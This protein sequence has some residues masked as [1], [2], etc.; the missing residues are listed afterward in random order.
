M[1]I[2][3]LTMANLS[4]IWHIF[5]IR[6][7]NLEDRPSVVIRYISKSNGCRALKKLLTVKSSPFQLIPKY[8]HQSFLHWHWPNWVI[9]KPYTQSVVPIEQLIACADVFF[10]ITTI[11]CFRFRCVAL[12]LEH[13]RICWA[14]FLRLYS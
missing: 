10:W 4:V 2:F 1:S 7:N 14:N 12:F 11:H 9:H 8:M 3:S 6:R 5:Y 13:L